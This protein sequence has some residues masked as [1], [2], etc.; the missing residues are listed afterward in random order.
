MA[1]VRNQE[2]INEIVKVSFFNSELLFL[3]KFLCSMAFKT[4]SYMQIDFI[5]FNLI[6]CTYPRLLDNF[7]GRGQ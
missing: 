1:S 7:Q 3:E 6:G 5:V 2:E 4:F